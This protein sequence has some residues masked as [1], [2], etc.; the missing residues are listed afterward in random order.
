MTFENGQ[1]ISLHP[2]TERLVPPRTSLQNTPPV[3]PL[4]VEKPI[5]QGVNLP[6]V[7]MATGRQFTEPRWM[8]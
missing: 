1:L 3:M 8:D 4:W 7:P 2:P 5:E 6:N